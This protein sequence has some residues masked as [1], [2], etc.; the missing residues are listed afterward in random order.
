MLP[1]DLVRWVNVSLIKYF[2]EIA[3]TN[4][5]TMYV[6]GVDERSEATM[7]TNHSELR[8]QGPYVRKLSNN[9]W[10][11]ECEV[12][13]EMTTYMSMSGENAYTIKDWGGIF[14]AAMEAPINV[15]KY[16]DGGAL[17]GCLRVK[18][19][20]TNQIKHFDFGVAQNNTRVRQAEVDARFELTTSLGE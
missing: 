16:G 1:T 7:R 8:I 3:S 11:I 14:M 9:V 20:R 5:I 10:K 18:Q 12:N 4:G 19:D 17:I 2:T 15:Y 13:I 6:E